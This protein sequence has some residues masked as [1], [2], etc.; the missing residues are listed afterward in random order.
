MHNYTMD[1]KKEHLENLSDL[2]LA[3]SPSVL[4]P[5]MHQEGQAWRVASFPGRLYT[6]IPLV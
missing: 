4:H 3:I 2:T 1:P 5:L 6:S